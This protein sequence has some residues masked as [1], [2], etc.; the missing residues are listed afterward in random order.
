MCKLIF[1]QAI[2]QVF[3]IPEF[4][5]EPYT[6]HIIESIIH[7]KSHKLKALKQCTRNE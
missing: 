4:I 7:N 2:S 6:G 1:T 3:K 5:F